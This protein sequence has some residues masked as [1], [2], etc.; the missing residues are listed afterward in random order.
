VSARAVAKKSIGREYLEALLVA[1]I[2]VTFARVF[3]FQ[4]FKIPTGSMIDNLLVGDHIIVNKFVYGPQGPGAVA[5]LFPFRAVQ[6]GDV[7]V[8]RY[9]EDPDIDFVKRVIA[10]PG[11]TIEIRDKVVHI[12]GR[13]L[14]EAYTIFRDPVVVPDK[15]M[16]PRRAR[17]QFGPFEVP[18]GSYF[19]MGDNRDN[20]RDSRFWGPVPAG[21]IKGR[22]FM[23]YWSYEGESTG[24][25]ASA[26]ARM[27]ELLGV[28]AHLIPRTRWKR[29]FFVVDSEYH[30]GADVAEGP[31]G[32]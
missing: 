29:T 17:D 1:V 7:V 5:R 14:D 25:D 23:V 20:S 3:V 4:A 30:Y 2:F 31:T 12:D 11:E 32:E 22:A 19:V 24:S 26:G 28:V 9:P 18:R 6:R 8:F 27:R 10:L 15:P 13:P 21:M 16:L